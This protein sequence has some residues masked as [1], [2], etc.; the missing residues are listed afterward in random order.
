MEKVVPCGWGMCVC[1]SWSF[2]NVRRWK[3][4][5]I[6]QIL[7]TIQIS[8]GFVGAQECSAR[9][10]GVKVA[11]HQTVEDGDFWLSKISDFSSLLVGYIAAGRRRSLGS[12]AI[13]Y[14]LLW[15]KTLWMEIE[16]Y[17]NTLIRISPTIRTQRM[18]LTETRECRRLKF[19]P[20]RDGTDSI[21]NNLGPLTF[22]AV[23]KTKVRERQRLFRM[24]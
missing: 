1:P 10:Q 18:L 7:R 15:C 5:H 24:L 16:K 17:T 11:I 2:I 23:G 12:M 9:A 3:V 8:L 13:M 22:A 6:R 20:L 4:W 19:L 14:S 21:S